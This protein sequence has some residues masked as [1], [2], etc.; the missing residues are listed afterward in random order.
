MTSVTPNYALAGTAATPIAIAGA[1]F[2]GG[3]TVSFTPP[4]GA[5]TPIPPN[6]IQ[7]A[8]ILAT[9]PAAFL[10][11]PGTA[12]VA[13]VNGLGASSNPVPFI[14]APF[15]VTSVT[16]STVPVGTA[17]APVTVAGANLSTATALSFTPP[18]G[19]SPTTLSLSLIQAAQ[20]T[21]TIPA[22]FLTTPGTAQVA[23]LNGAGAS[24][25]QLPFT[26]TPATTPT[27]H[28]ITNGADFSPPPLAPGSLA[29]I[30]G[31]SLASVTANAPAGQLP[32]SLGNV[33]VKVDGVAAPILFVNTGQIN[34]QIPYETA[35]GT[36]TVTVTTGVGTSNTLAFPVVAAAPGIGAPVL[37]AD[38]TAN[39]A[40][41]P[42]APGAV[43]AV[44]LTG[45]G[46]VNPSIADEARS[47]V[48]C[49]YARCGVQRGNRRC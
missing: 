45:I 20:A 31:S 12:Q 4:G 24:S 46:A 40:A 8:Q 13:V 15:L 27:I 19:G 25:N 34:F 41:N 22:A 35:L 3:S 32:T 29:T 33:T 7:A 26:I 21:A 10:T 37:N 43:I 5:P 30:F 48:A 1:N 6:L 16:P 11:S 39:S 44:T 14:V 23:L 18:G 28:A 38:G 47:R 36:A 42:A 49:A 9:I 17:D 2:G